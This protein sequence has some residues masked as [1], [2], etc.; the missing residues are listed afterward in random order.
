MKINLDVFFLRTQYLHLISCTSQ[1][2]LL[3]RRRRPSC[4]TLTTSCI[5]VLW[6]LNYYY[7]R[8]HF[9]VFKTNRF[10]NLVFILLFL[11]F[12]EES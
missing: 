4:S 11:V 8:C 10:S 12:Y 9:F 5:I 2:F 1:N 7:L 3:K 6:Y